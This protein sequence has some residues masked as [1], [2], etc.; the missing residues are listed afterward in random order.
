[1]RAQRSVD[2]GGYLRAFGLYARN[3][4][5]VLPPLVAGIAGYGITAFSGQAAGP[6]GALTGGLLNLVV[7]LL[8]CFALAFSVIIGDLAWRRGAAALGEA[9][10][11]AQ[12]RT[13]DILMA[14]LGLTFLIYVA[15]S[16][17]GLGI[18]APLLQALASYFFIYTIPAAAIGGIPGGA[19]L[20]VSIERVQSGYA[21]AFVLCVV[22]VIFIELFRFLWTQAVFE[23][24]TLSAFFASPL[25]AD[26]IGVAIKSLGI[27]YLALVMA[28][29]Y[30]D[31][32]YGRRY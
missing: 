19:A 11:E 7:T 24:S 12:R 18:L 4:W 22:F 30:N 27:G 13:G 3:P 23:L 20:S 28:R 16:F 31:V 5:I 8:D 1:V 15:G 29:A 21:V 17:I 14:S 32:S 10:S 2:F 9:W 6:G 25:A 26:L